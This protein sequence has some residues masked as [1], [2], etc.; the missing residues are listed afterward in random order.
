MK[1]HSYFIAWNEEK[2]LPHL[3][4]YYSEFCDKIVIYDNES[5]DRTPEIIDACPKAVR[6]TWCHTEINEQRYLE[7]K[8]S[9]YKE[10]RGEA[11]WV[12]V[13]DA[14]EFI[15]HPNLLERLEFYKNT[16]VTLP[17]VI[18]Y[19][20]VPNC[21]LNPDENLP[22]VYQNGARTTNFD[23]RMIFNP[24]LDVHFNVGCHTITGLPAGAIES[25]DSLYLMH[26]KKLN[27]EYYV[28]RQRLLGTR[29]SAYNRAH[30][31]AIQYDWSA[32]QLNAEYHQVLNSC[33][34]IFGQDVNNQ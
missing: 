23:K 18:G 1:I 6:H 8:Q 13:G 14:D 4:R 26:F 12:I 5:T 33:K 20:M 10:S 17:K 11:D 21:E 16:G 30:H 32:E 7:I 24:K 27:L 2:I 28:N 3:L 19:E 25:Q 29:Q 34:P 22:F 9:C 31:L 15:F